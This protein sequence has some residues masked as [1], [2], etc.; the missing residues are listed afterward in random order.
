MSELSDY[1][2]KIDAID[3]QLLK[4][5]NERASLAREVGKVKNRD[6]LPIYAPD[7]E[8]ALLRGLIEK[9]DGPLSP[10]A[11][12][13]IY[14]EIMSAALAL[15]K[16]VVIA[17]FGPEGGACH[18]AAKARFGSSV[19]YAFFPDVSDLFAAVGKGESDCGVVPIEDAGHGAVNQTLDALTATDLMICAEITSTPDGT[20]GESENSS[21]YFVMAR[22]SDMNRSTP[23]S[24][25]SAAGGMAGIAASV[26][27]SVTKPLP[28]T[29]AAPFD[30][31][32]RIAR[33]DNCSRADRCTPLACAT[34]TA[35]IVM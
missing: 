18:Q 12:R 23:T 7:R 5:L 22:T 8:M 26:A 11:I 28:V 29:P 4:L 16:D 3:T 30:V 21:R 10:T 19:S 31:S 15:E 24:S 13:A 2:E 9:S 34:K 1:R 17:C 35:A 25:A 6:G 20:P 32:I 27:A 14:R 33:I